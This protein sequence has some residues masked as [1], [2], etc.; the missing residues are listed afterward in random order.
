MATTGALE[1]FRCRLA[2]GAETVRSL[3]SDYPLEALEAE[4]VRAEQDLRLSEVIEAD[5]ANQLFAD[6]LHRP[7]LGRHFFVAAAGRSSCFATI[8]G[9]E[10]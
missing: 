2:A 7:H 10:G 3:G 8:H 9:L 5:G 6:L 4:G 1:L